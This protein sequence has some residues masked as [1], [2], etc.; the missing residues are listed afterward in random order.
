MQVRWRSFAV[1]LALLLSGCW[2]SRCSIDREINDLASLVDNSPVHPVSDPSPPPK[3]EPA[4][5]VTQTAATEEPPVASDEPAPPPRL[6]VVQERD[7]PAEG[8]KPRTLM[9]PPELPG[10]EDIPLQLPRDLAERLR[11][12]QERFSPTPPVPP[13]LLLAPGPEGRPMSLGDLQRL[14]ATYS[15]TIR[16]A[17]AA[18]KAAAG[19][20]KQAG[21]YPNPSF[22][23]EQDTV[24]TGPAGYEG[25]GVNQLIKT[26]NKLKLQQAAAMM[27]LLNTRLALRRAYTDLASQVRGNYFAVL[28]A[29]ESV[30]LNLALFRF[31]EAIYRAQVDYLEKGFAATYECRQLRTLVLA[32]RLNLIQAQ[33]Q[34]LASWKQ[35]TATLGLRDMGPAELEGRIDLPVPVFD[36]QRVLDQALQNHT[37]VRAAINS[38][39]KARFNLELAK[40]IPLPDVGV[41]VLIQKDYTTPPNQVVHS[42][43]VSLPTP[44]WDQNKGGILQAEG[45]LEQALA[46]PEQ[47]RN[48]LTNTLADAFNRYETNR[49]TVEISLQ[50]VRDQLRAYRGLYDR[51]EH[52]PTNVGFGDL[53]TAQQTL[54]GYIAGYITALGLQWQAVVDVANVLQTDDLFQVGP[55]QE[56][57]PVP[58]LDAVT[59]PGVLESCKRPRRP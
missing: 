21:A 30:K 29:Q 28:V 1:G 55:T 14:A 53:V 4:P 45:Q 12:L 20:A 42:L 48:S 57:V 39:Q 22:F 37:D 7:K 50:Q 49:Q 9:V 26:G 8:R 33:N 2:S 16:N 43:Q 31:T 5:T 47:A 18:V 6:A 46:G 25:F 11:Y 44:L 15:P 10:A 24:Q 40:V 13:L 58:D 3:Q 34:Y 56:M 51:R 41:N 32:A 59:P 52:D 38:I 17:A 54:A 36:Y 27:D 19:A 23:F 35:L